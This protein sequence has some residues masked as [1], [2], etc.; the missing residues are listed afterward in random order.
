V[1]G[2]G[3]RVGMM[4]TDAMFAFSHRL[5]YRY[6]CGEVATRMIMN[7]SVTITNR[8]CDEPS[9]SGLVP[10]TLTGLHEYALD[11]FT[12]WSR[13]AALRFLDEPSCIMEQGL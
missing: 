11:G 9:A 13:D 8:C 5:A 6:C 4:C 12:Q 10:P 3:T 7:T 1:R 2:G